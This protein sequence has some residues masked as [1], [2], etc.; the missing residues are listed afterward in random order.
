[1]NGSLGMSAK[2]LWIGS[3]KP[4]KRCKGVNDNE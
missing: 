3:E 1:M 2:G 4:K